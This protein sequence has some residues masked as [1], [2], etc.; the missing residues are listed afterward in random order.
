MDLLKIAAQLF[1]Q[2]I[3]SST[4]NLDSVAGALTQ[5]LPTNGGSLDIGA[6]VSQFTQNGGGLASL[7]QSWLGDGANQSF[8]ASDV[9]GFFGQD[10]V[11][12]FSNQ[13]GINTNEATSGLSQMIPELIDKSSEGGNLLQDAGMKFAASAL[14]KLF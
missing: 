3:G 10:K 14:S 8:N 4:L 12:A 13:L 9:L 1:A 7:A 2:K 11:S 5:L 6:L